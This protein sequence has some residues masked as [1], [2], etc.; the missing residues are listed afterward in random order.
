MGVR[1]PGV[2]TN[3]KVRGLGLSVGLAGFCFPYLFI[4]MLNQS[5][6]VFPMCSFFSPIPPAVVNNFHV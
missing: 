3:Y 6:E 5:L 4:G 1:R 2:E